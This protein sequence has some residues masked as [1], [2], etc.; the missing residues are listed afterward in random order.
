MAKRE[1]FW[2]SDD[3]WK[4][5]EQHLPHGKP[6]KPRVDDRRV[7]SG[8]LHVLKVG[9]RWRDVP[10]EYGPAKTVYN[11]YHRWSQRRIWQRM[12]EKMAASGSVSEEL[13]IDSTHVK[14]HRSAQGSKGG[15]GNRRSARRGAEEQAK[16]IVWPMIAAD[17]SLL[18]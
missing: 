4:A 15:R 14:A 17:R 10:P 5:L 16:S 9:C 12:F 8:I 1:L 11:R 18:P 3:A 2:L 7:I 6:G 13:S